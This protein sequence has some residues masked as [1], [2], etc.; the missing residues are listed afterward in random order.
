M[1]FCQEFPK[2]EPAEK[3]RFSTVVTRLLSGHV[4]TPGSPLRPEPEWRFAERH[5]ELIDAYLRLGGW[6]FDIDLGLRLGRAVHEGGE[7]RVRFTKLESLIVCLLRLVYHEQMRDVAEELRCELKVGDLKERLI[8]AGRPPAQVTRRAVADALRRLARH[9]IVSCERG[10]TGEDDEVFQ[11]SS[12]IEKILPPDRIAELAERVRS[13]Q[14]PVEVEDS[15]S[16][17]GLDDGDGSTP[18]AGS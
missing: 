13:Y 4:L 8:Q 7:Q 14:T 10:F 18:E 11:V 17:P 6:R 5:R 15:E 2:L 1:E 16:T 9:S 3:E 12:L